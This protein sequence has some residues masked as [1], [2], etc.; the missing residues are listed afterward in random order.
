MASTNKMMRRLKLIAASS[1]IENGS[2]TNQ[3]KLVIV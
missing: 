3:I 2:N 1:P